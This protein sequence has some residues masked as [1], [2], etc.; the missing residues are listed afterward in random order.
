[1]LGVS[2]RRGV[3]WW[4][5]AVIGGTPALAQ[6]GD[7][8][9]P[10][11]SLRAC[12]EAGP[13]PGGGIA[14]LSVAEDFEAGF[15]VGNI[16]NQNGWKGPLGQ[17]I[18]T[19]TNPVGG[20]LS[21]RHVSNGTGS[22]A[23]TQALNSPVFPGGTQ[24]GTFAADV[25]ITAATTEYHF[26]TRDTAV[27]PPSNYF[28]TRVKFA[29][30]GDIEVAQADP[31]ELVFVYIDSG[32]NW[33]VGAVHRVCI[34][35][36][37]ASG[38]LNVYLDG[39][40]IFTG[41]DTQKII[42][43]VSHGIGDYLTYSNNAGPGNANGSG[44]TY[45]LDNLSSVCDPAG[46]PDP[47]PADAVAD[48]LVDVQ[49]LIAVILA[50]SS[51]DPAADVTGDGVVDVLDLVAVILAWG[52]CPLVNDDC[53]DA[54]EAGDGAN[55]F[56]TEGAT[57]DAGVPAFTCGPAVSDV[58]FDYTATCGGT[59][60]LTT[61]G[62]DFDA[63]LAVYQ[64]HGCPPGTLLACDD[65]SGGGGAAA[66]TLSVAAGQDLKIRVGVAAGAGA[67]TLSITCTPPG[68]PV[69]DACASAT[70]LTLVGGQ[71]QAIGQTDT[72]TISPEALPCASICPMSGDVWF[73]V[74]GTG[75]LMTATLCDPL[76]DFDTVMLVYCGSDCSSLGCVTADDEGCGVPGTGVASEVMWCS[77]AGQTY[78]INVQGFR[79]VDTGGFKLRVIDG[80]TCPAP[81]P[82][83]P[84]PM[85]L[86]NDDCPDAIP[87]TGDVDQP[88][89]T[90]GACTDGVAHA[91]CQFDGQTYQDLWYRYTAACD[92]FIQVS[93]CNLSMFDSDLAVYTAAGWPGTCPPGDAQLLACADD[94][95]P[96]C[97]DFG[98]FLEIDG[99]SAGEQFLIRVGGHQEGNQGVG[100][101]SI[102]CFDGNDFCAQAEEIGPP[103]NPRGAPDTISDTTCGATTE[104][105]PQCGGGLVKFAPG[106]WYTALGDGSTFTASL[107]A[108]QSGFDTRL[109]VYCG[110][111]AQIDA[112]SDCAALEFPDNCDNGFNEELSWCTEPGREYLILV[113][114]NFGCGQYTLTLTSDAQACGSPACSC[115]VTCT[116]QQEPEP[117]GSD[118]NGGCLDGGQQDMTPVLHGQTWC[119]SMW[120]VGGM[121]DTDWYLLSVGGG[122][123]VTATL[124]AEL[125]GVVFILRD[126]PQNCSGL[127]IVGVA[128][129]DG[130]QA[131]A[132]SISGL[133]P[134]ESV[135]IFVSTE[136]LFGPIFDGFPCGASSNYRLS[137]SSQ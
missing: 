124:T 22:P 80:P 17:A 61:A 5:A 21:A 111:C 120:A 65:D 100:T 73:R 38:V 81:P 33:V 109:T 46:P 113:H 93:T 134:G 32:A 47:C 44:A 40:L 51:S 135:Y 54:Q 53:A 122:G 11:R 10:A 115:Q 41:L 137:I 59:L 63:L 128:H 74:Q 1:M 34:E 110:P 91:A 60:Q 8:C 45:T 119:G 15:V 94:T 37:D 96:M 132:A 58:W 26:I 50:W 103:G 29:I 101:L 77:A 121:R 107:C 97:S 131:A 2:K 90:T 31:D 19:A 71:A 20:A 35:V 117:C 86:P 64:G 18:I 42:N 98:A 129:S 84:G 82:C 83:Q 89:N 78:W 7:P 62:S 27:A 88:Y 67:G 16:Q 126:Q 66:V 3:I 125:P 105:L 24:F 95:F 102:R 76:T 52:P 130:C 114:G 70:V 108:S 49:D 48:G 68:P 4:A 79:A 36:V 6:K 123:S 72:A 57:L 25:R 12:D 14:G 43:N 116:G 39:E 55:G 9:D 28:N 13:G 69:N 104:I 127:Q 106:R 30:D 118:V 75:H 85:P 56:I 92:G 99:V 133:N 136:D 87:L 112:T 23:N